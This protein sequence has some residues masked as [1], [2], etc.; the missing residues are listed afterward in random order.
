[1]AASASCF[2]AQLFRLQVTQLIHLREGGDTSSLD[3]TG[4]FPGR[5]S[6]PSE[7]S[8]SE[9]VALGWPEGVGWG[10]R[11]GEGSRAHPYSLHASRLLEN[12]SRMWPSDPRASQGQPHFQEVIWVLQCPAGLGENSRNILNS[13]FETRLMELCRA[14]SGQIPISVAEG[15]RLLFTDGAWGSLASSLLY[16]AA[17][18]RA[19]G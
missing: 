19:R 16:P 3:M 12:N 11:R 7:A 9:L 10:F 2:I 18:R 17:L 14:A 8:G 13:S 6:I 4:P 15:W 1:M 5:S